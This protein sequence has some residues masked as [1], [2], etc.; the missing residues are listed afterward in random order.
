MS[1]SSERFGWVSKSA[2]IILAGTIGLIV[3]ALAFTVV[4]GV[5]AYSQNEQWWDL[6]PYVI[7]AVI[8]I[9]VIGWAIMQ[10]AAC[11]V[12]VAGEQSL[13]N[14]EGR[15]SRIETLLDDVS[16]SQRKMVE[17]A[18]L[19]DQAKSLIFRDRE[20]EAMRET[21]HEDIIQQNYKSA[22]SLIDSMEKRLG[23]VDEAARLRSEVEASR[24]GTEQEKI[25]DATQ[26]IQKSISDKQWAAAMRESQ[27]IQK[28]F[29]HI[30]KLSEL[31]GQIDSARAKH[32]RELLEAY[33]EAVRKNDV[34]RSIELLK[35]LDMYLS[36]QEGAAMEES[37]RGVFRAK[38]HN[39]GMQFAISVT[40]EQWMD[41]A[42]VG[43]EIVRQYP[44]TR[45]AQEVLQ[46]MDMLKARASSAST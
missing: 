41:A 37:A 46:K 1:E 2:R 42:Y 35:E 4:A 12:M 36:P 24:L 32:K 11:K 33:D 44:N 18:S 30:S 25:D 15:L 7:A 16:K 5:A 26:R 9:V 28:A 20:I 23:Y 43:Q 10:F 22:Q 3:M 34:D 31:P 14:A 39:L 6:Y 19:S 13:S 38:L 17:L 40:E 29:P 27:R 45:M 21:I 8:E